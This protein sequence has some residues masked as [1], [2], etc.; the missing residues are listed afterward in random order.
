MKPIEMWMLVQ[1]S[2]LNHFSLTTERHE[3][4]VGRIGDQLH[5]K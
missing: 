3:V 1:E 4:A 5:Y 2:I